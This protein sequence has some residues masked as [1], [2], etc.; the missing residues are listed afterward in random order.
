MNSFYYDKKLLSSSLNKNRIDVLILAGGSD[1]R[2]YE[3]LRILNSTNKSIDKII[4]FEFNERISSLELNDSYYEYESYVDKP[5]IKINCHIKNPTSCLDSILDNEVIFNSA[6]DIYMDISCFTKPYFFYVIKLLKERFQ[7]P[8]INIL[9]TEPESYL[10]PR[11]IFHKYQSTSGPLSILEIPGFSGYEQ[12]GENRIL[13]ILL[14]F[15]GDLSKEINEDVSP[16]ET[17][18]VNGFSGYLPKFKDISLVANEKLISNKDIEVKYSRADNPFEIFNLLERI[19][20]RNKNTFINIAPLGTKP[21]ALGACLFAM[22]Y[23]NVR[24]VYPFPESYKK[25]TTHQCWNSWR[26]K[27]PLDLRILE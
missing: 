13:I 4:F 17:I 12:R 11:G 22:F 14:G 23:S 8:E 10:F 7:I 2:A 26:Y 15:D 1:Y 24:I 3:S 18:V 9:Y 27:I 5:I 21:M 16:K 6:K 20:I 25:I 19:K